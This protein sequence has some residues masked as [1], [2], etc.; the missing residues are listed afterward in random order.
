MLTGKSS[1]TA[2][3]P[4][5]LFIN[6]RHRFSCQFLSAI[7]WHWSVDWRMSRGNMRAAGQSSAPCQ[8]GEFNIDVW[9][10]EARLF[11][12]N[13]NHDRGEWMFLKTPK[14]VPKDGYLSQGC[15][16]VKAKKDLTF[17]F[18]I[19][20]VVFIYFEWNFS[21]LKIWPT[22]ESREIFLQCNCCRPY[23]V[24]LWVKYWDYPAFEGRMFFGRST[25]RLAFWEIRAERGLLREG[26]RILN[27][28]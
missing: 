18:Q 7:A 4:F 6:A 23:A 8:S 25:A 22:R 15:L 26:Y 12:L 27:I 24:T 16:E 28:E 11:C 21:W 1:V 3:S 17:W 19:R 5:A 2:L 20:Y 9:M 13:M 14:S 10:K